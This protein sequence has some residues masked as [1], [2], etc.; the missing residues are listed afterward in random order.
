MN[1][2]GRRGGK[3]RSI[4]KNEECGGGTLHG[5]IIYEGCVSLEVQKSEDDEHILFRSVELDDSPL[6]KIGETVGNF[7]I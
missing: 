7:I 3:T 4:W 2:V 1:Y 5:A 6:R